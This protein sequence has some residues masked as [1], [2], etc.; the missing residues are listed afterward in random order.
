MAQIIK[1]MSNEEYHAH[2][3]ISKSSLDKIAK[4][5]LHY[6]RHYLSDDKPK[7]IWSDALVTGSV[8]HSLL[9]EPQNFDKDFAVAPKIN[10][11]TKA[12]KEE[13]EEFV[14]DNKG[15]LIVDQKIFD[16]CQRMSSAVENHPLASQYCDGF[17][18]A[19]QSI[20]WKWSDDLPIECRCRPDYIRTDGVLVDLKSSITGTKAGFPRKAFDFRYHVQAAFYSEGYKAAYGEYPKEFVFVVVEKTDP[21]PVSVFKATPEFLQA[22][23]M[24][25]I[26]DLKTLQECRKTCQWPG[27][28]NDQVIDL[29]LPGY[30]KAKYERAFHE[31]A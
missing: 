22:G 23:Y 21:Y 25:L 8:F 3:S 2:P 13:W 27:Y 11:R 20:F 7:T 5:P 17:G 4:S 10:K 1:D 28:E 14:D 26:A 29:E 19:E 9:L 24:D 15:K 31:A 16:L 12:G 18:E 6:W 30:I